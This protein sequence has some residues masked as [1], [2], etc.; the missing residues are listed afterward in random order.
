MNEEESLSFTINKSQHIQKFNCH[1]KR[2]TKGK[3]DCSFLW[4][5]KRQSLCNK[6]ILLC[7]AGNKF[8][9]IL[10]QAGFTPSRLLP[11]DCYSINNYGIGLTDLVHTE[12]GN[13]NQIS[14]ESYEVDLFIKK[15]KHFKPKSASKLFKT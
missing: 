13:D 6:R 5:S 7:W 12:S 3:F 14:K 2:C 9:A 1:A 10:Y 15:M 11:T 4:H 8:Y